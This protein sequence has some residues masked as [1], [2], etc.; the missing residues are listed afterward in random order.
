MYNNIG[1][2]T[3][4]GTGTNGY[5]QRNFAFLPKER[6]RQPA[7]LKRNTEGP[8]QR[9]PN[10]KLLQRQKLRA[11]ES[12]VFNLRCKLED[13]DL[14]VAEIDA[15]CT[16]LREDLKKKLEDGTF[17]GAQSLGSH[18]VAAAQLRKN[19]ILRNALKIGKTHVVGEAFDQ[20]LQEEKRQQRIEERNKDRSLE[21]RLDDLVKHPLARDRKREDR[22]RRQDRDRDRTRDRR[23]RDRDG[24]RD[25]DRRDDHDRRDR[26]RRRRREESPSSPRKRRRRSSDRERRGEKDDGG[27]WKPEKSSSRRN[28]SRERDVKK[29]ETKSPRKSREDEDKYSKMLDKHRSQQKKRKEKKKKSRSP[30]SSGSDSDG[31]SS[32]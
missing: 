22:D 16:A 4:R 10:K 8:K 6:E 24:D 27:R 1:H 25:R 9:K 3:V 30:S 32:S 28:E 7:A 20:E 14:P 23:D 26:G 15:K 11:V 13:Q 12:E 17:S 21:E 5:I 29:E 18:Q 19:E 2:Q 31:S